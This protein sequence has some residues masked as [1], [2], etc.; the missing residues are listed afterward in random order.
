MYVS[1]LEALGRIRRHEPVVQRRHPEHPEA[2]FVMSLCT[3]DMLL[4]EIDATERLAVVSALV[5]T[6]KRIHI[7][8]ANDARPSAKKKDIGKTPNSLV[9]RKVVVD[10]LGRIRWAND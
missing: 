4:A 2:Q 9:A 3:G 8:D 1:L 5:S 7:V 6:Q 10:P